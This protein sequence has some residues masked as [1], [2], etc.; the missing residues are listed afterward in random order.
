MEDELSCY[1][2]QGLQADSVETVAARLRP[3]FALNGWTWFD[4]DQPP[5]AERIEQ[6]LR[7]FLVDLAD[8]STY[9][10]ETGRIKVERDKDF[11]CFRV[12]VEVGIL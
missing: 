3:I 1:E 11:D 10:I 4:S 8:G 7:N 9:G 5:T 12:F 2:E 6:T